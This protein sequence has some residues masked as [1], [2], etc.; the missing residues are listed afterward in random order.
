MKP[1]FTRG[2][3]VTWK[4]DKGFGLIKANH[5]GKDA[6]LHI[7]VLPENSRPPKVGDTILYQRITTPKG[8]VRATKA[9]IIGIKPQAPKPQ[10]SNLKRYRFGK[11]GRIEALATGFG[12][13]AITLVILA[14]SNHRSPDLIKAIF[15]SSCTLKGNIST[16]RGNKIYYLPD[17]DDYEITVISSE[18][19][20]Q[21]VVYRSSDDSCAFSIRKS[22]MVASSVRPMART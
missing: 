20:W 13:A 21:N 3:L 6:F 5:G 10:A 22:R 8:K 9:S 15:K 19:C 17:A 4:E 18:F 11:I 1:I 14:F 16:N 7:S 2:R 12:L